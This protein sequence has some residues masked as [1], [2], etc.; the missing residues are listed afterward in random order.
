L[1]AHQIVKEM[2]NFLKNTNRNKSDNFDDI[3]YETKPMSAPSFAD[4]ALTN[5]EASLKQQQHPHRLS[6][7]FDTSACP[8]YYK[9]ALDRVKKQQD[10]T[11]YRGPNDY[12]I[13]SILNIFIFVILA[14][15]ALFFSVQTRDM[16]RIGNYQKAKHY[17]KRA[18][19]LNILASALGLLAITLALIFRFALYHLFVQNDVNSQSFLLTAGG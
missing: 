2:K 5:Y 14:L 12:M 7:N 17:S 10:H 3:E 9:D 4:T 19:W 8:A 16:K 11:N 18:L 1:A 6:K 13:W 15:P